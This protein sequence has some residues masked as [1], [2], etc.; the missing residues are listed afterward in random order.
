METLVKKLADLEEAEAIALAKSELEA[1]ADPLKILDACRAGMVEVGERYES[2]DY[3]VS[4]LMMAAEI[5]KQVAA[6]VEPKLAGAVAETKGTVVMGT[7]QGD[8]H[9]IGKDL[10]V[11]MLRASGYEVHDLGVDVAPDAFVA[12]VQETGAK[13]L[14]LSG[15]LTVAFD[16]MKE[17]V[18]AVEG[19]GL[20]P[21]V[22][23]MVGGGPVDETVCEYTGADGW[24][25]SA[26]KAVSLAAEWMEG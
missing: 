2:G 5:F 25:D 19:A 20:R 17:T 11:G 3:F 1:G 15:L 22:K 18:A 24:G 13:V 14:G 8:V 21:G 23:V 4:D 26:Q 6:M 12:K 16:A 10:T 9:D 7:V